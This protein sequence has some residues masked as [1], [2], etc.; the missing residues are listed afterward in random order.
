MKGFIAK[1]MSV[2]MVISTIMPGLNQAIVY[3]QES[4]AIPLNTGGI[5]IQASVDVGLTFGGNN[6]TPNTI[7]A[8]PGQEI[9]QGSI[10][11]HLDTR[12]VST[13]NNIKYYYLLDPTTKINFIVNETINGIYEA[14]YRVF[15]R[16]DGEWILVPA[17]PSQIQVHSATTA[18]FVPATELMGVLGED[19]PTHRIR[20]NED[21]TGII[22]G[23]VPNQGFSFRQNGRTVHF[24]M[25]ASGQ[26]IRYVT[27]GIS[28][29]VIYNFYAQDSTLSGH[30][31]FFTGIDTN[32]IGAIPFTSGRTDGLDASNTI[33]YRNTAYE[34][35]YNN[36]ELPVDPSVGM[37]IR[38]QEPMVLWIDENTNPNYT[39]SSLMGVENNAE[40]TIPA[41]ISMND[42]RG[43]SDLLEIRINNILELSANPSSINIQSSAETQ[44][45]NDSFAK[46]IRDS[47]INSNLP[48]II[49][50][51][52]TELIPSTLFN[53]LRIETPGIVAEGNTIATRAARL[54]PLGTAYTFPLYTYIYQDGEFSIE[55]EPYVGFSGVYVLTRSGGADGTGG[56]VRR[57]YFDGSQPIVNIPLPSEIGI[58]IN[59]VFQ[60]LFTPNQTIDSSLIT[61]LPNMLYSERTNYTPTPSDM[62]IGSPRNFEITEYNLR[63]LDIYEAPSLWGTEGLLKMNLRWSVGSASYIRDIINDTEDKFI[64]ITYAVNK[65]LRP[66]ADLGTAFAYIDM[67]IEI[68]Q[69]NNLQATYT[70]RHLNRDNGNVLDEGLVIL[71]EDNQGLVYMEV[72]MELPATRSELSQS[73]AENSDPNFLYPRI[74]YLNMEV[75]DGRMRAS[76]FESITLNDLLRP[77]LPPLQNFNI[78]EGSTTDNSVELNWNIPGNEVLDYIENSSFPLETLGEELNLGVNL[79]ISQNENL[80]RELANLDGLEARRLFSSSFLAAPLQD[81]NTITLG[82]TSLNDLRND[83]IVLIENINIGDYTNSILNSQNYLYTLGLEGLDE[84]Q[85]YYVYATLVSTYEVN[86]LRDEYESILSQLLGFTTAG[87]PNIPDDYDRIPSP[88]NLSIRDIGLNTATLYWPYVELHTVDS[89]ISVHYEIVRIRNEQMDNRHLN[90]SA[91]IN[92]FISIISE[93]MPN[94]ELTFL[95]TPP[96][97]GGNLEIYN[98]TSFVPVNT[99]EY[100]LVFNP[101]QLALTDNALSSNQIY[102]Y[103]I[104]TVR[105]VEIDNQ[106]HVAHSEWSAETATTSTLSAPINLRVD[107]SFNNYDPMTEFMIR[108]DAPILN[109]ELLRSETAF[110]YSIRE[111]DGDFSNPIRMDAQLLIN[112]ASN[113][114][115]S[116]HTNF[117]YK[118]SGLKPNTSYTVRVHMRNLLTNDTSPWSNNVTT[119][120]QFNQDVVN[121]E[122]EL[123]SWLDY[124]KQ[125]LQQLI[126]DPY[127]ILQDANNEFRVVYRPSMFDN[128]LNASVDSQILLAQSDNNVNTHIYYIPSSII[129]KAN[130]QEKGFTIRIDDIEVIIPPKALNPNYNEELLS[131][132]NYIRNGDIEDYYIRI[133]AIKTRFTGNIGGN[134]P[135]S[136]QIQ[137]SFEVVGSEVSTVKWDLD[138]LEMYLN[139]IDLEARS[140]IV[141]N[142]LLDSLRRGRPYD[143]MVRR[144][145]EFVQEFKRDLIRRTNTSFNRERRINRTIHELDQS[146]IIIY[147]ENQQGLVVNGYRWTGRWE[148]INTSDFLGFK[149]IR[150]NIPGIFVFAGRV[151]TVP[152]LAQEPNA[153]LAF[154]IIT[155]YSLDEAL[156]INGT[157]NLDTLS[158]RH[159]FIESVARIAGLPTGGN[160]TQF[161]TNKGYFVPGGNLQTHISIQEAIY[162]MMSIYEIRTD[163]KLEAISI[164]NHSATANIQGINARY[165]PSIRAAFEIG[166]YSNTDMVPNGNI[167]LRQMLEM[168]TLL[169]TKVSL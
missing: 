104:R 162:L 69:G 31:K 147:R 9:S 120:T 122:N 111:E 134:E 18:T 15:N 112:S 84:N 57:I 87:I 168:L 129:H 107:N 76:T 106:V 27:D 99:S 169:D 8:L 153:G 119:R 114:S 66:E 83:N 59:S 4:T 75:L 151:V 110:Y 58:G 70:V 166:L 80:M 127:W 94:T 163:T 3:A 68:V 140:N 150:S 145:L 40:Y 105:T 47:D 7:T 101:T 88:P 22:F 60:I 92:E 135:L 67:R 97:E 115:E 137:V 42:N 146:M 93:D 154:S 17:D 48:R 74:Y 159:M 19:H 78:I 113:S 79:Y 51:R 164:R 108:F 95:Q 102:F 125:E 34:L 130:E 149:G 100:N 49:E 62:E 29:G 167:T 39:P 152:G 116:G 25:D 89:P 43:A 11:L 61:P 23:F 50:V 36:G 6:Y 141:R 90:T 24:R 33:N 32:N 45:G 38:F 53:A 56:E 128:L 85:R 81:G 44:P 91:N 5:S 10:H 160:S 73:E 156:G 124:Y 126:K 123:G 139:E 148:E 20:A 54:T 158:T 121:E 131:I 46:V 98:G 118:I 109:L 55:F 165:L 71:E 144:I 37:A 64:N 72:E 155:K 30:T 157:I 117:T 13:Q 35:D 16:I 138:I 132:N 65:A 41:L 142:W 161:L 96:H 133:T 82:G 26:G 1:I 103:Y 28:D 52:L 86:T 143:E 21:N 12:N 2:V 63:P 77:L 14:E 136:D